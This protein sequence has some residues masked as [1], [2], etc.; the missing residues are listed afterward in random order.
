MTLTTFSPERSKT[1]VDSNFDSLEQYH[2]D[3]APDLFM[4]DV[5]SKR[6][7][8][9]LLVLIA[10]W[11]SGVLCF[12]YWWFDRDH[13]VGSFG[14]VL[15]TLLITWTSVVPAYLLFFVVQMKRVN[16]SLPIPK[17]W[18]VAMITTRAPSEP[19][20]VVKETLQAML[21]QDYPHDTWLADEEP[22]EEIYE[23]CA[24]H[25]VLVSTRHNEPAYH[26]LTWPRRTKCKEG[27]LAFFYDNHG[28]A[29]YDFVAQLDADHVP[30]PGYLEAILRPFIDES[31]GY[32]SAPS[33]CDKNSRSSW[34]AR[35]RLYA[36]AIM[37][38][39]LQAG[40]SNGYAPLCIGSHYAVRTQALREIGG[41]GPELA[42]DHSTTLM[43]NG[44]GW[45]GIHAIDAIAHGEGPPTFADCVTQ[46]FQWSRSL[47][48]LLL[49]L[50]PKYWGHGQRT[51]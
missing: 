42:E 14:F 15:N 35:G 3:L 37:H 36:E 40:Y 8:R 24:E 50:L 29:N 31:V 51:L 17:S 11:I 9:N 2:T 34:S 19:F 47:M 22:S 20:S 43:M 13:V 23:W 33:I 32:V 38:G 26:R 16:P 1:V 41:L 5:L 39:P 45:R 7:Q 30:A 10:G 48:V 25:G 21:A 49:T 46:E 27:N 4:V 44:Y 28:Y 6:E 12:Y 18:R